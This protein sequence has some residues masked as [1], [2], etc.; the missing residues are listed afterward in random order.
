MLYVKKKQRPSS[1]AL[2]F[3]NLNALNQ[4]ATKETESNF[5]FDLSP[6]TCC[7]PERAAKQFGDL[8]HPAQN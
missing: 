8:L 7:P 4:L 5:T 2:P 3:L 1:V 6:A